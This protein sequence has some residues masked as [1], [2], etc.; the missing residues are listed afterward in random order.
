VYILHQA[1]F[2]ASKIEYDR[3]KQQGGTS[4]PQVVKT[5]TNTG[6]KVNSSEGLMGLIKQI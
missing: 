5:Q 4:K 3:W 2:L 1:D 6:K